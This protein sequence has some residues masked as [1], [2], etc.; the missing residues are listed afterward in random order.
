MIAIGLLGFAW[1]LLYIVRRSIIAPLVSH[2]TFNLAQLLK[3]LAFA[4]R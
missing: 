4:A 1:G 3:Y 2:A